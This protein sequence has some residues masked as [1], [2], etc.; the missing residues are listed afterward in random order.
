MTDS[1]TTTT[2]ATTAQ[3]RVEID[4]HAVAWLTLDNPSK[5]NAMSMPM[6]RAL[7]DALE[8]FESDPAVRCVVLTGQGDK[9]FCVGADISQ[10]EQIRSGPESSAEYEALTRSTLK[11][12]QTFPKPTIAMIAGYCLGAGAVLATSCDLRIGAVGSRY[13]IPAARLGIG[14]Q[15]SGVK[16]L[17][18][19]V[20]PGH[21]KRILYSADKYPAEEMLRIGFLEELV[22]ADQLATRV[23]SLARTIA[24]NAPLSIATS[25]HAIDAACSNEA[26]PDIAACT[27]GEY[28]CTASEDH[29]EGRRAFMEKRNPVFHGR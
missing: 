22:P 10:F 14:Y 17:T 18:D 23:Q 29:A 20:G 24:A 5:F 19:L 1:T 4:T 6:W 3:V 26:P 21:A 27:A 8:A 11:R 13:G 9:A 12:L 7:R 25:K 28:A 15:Y 16:R 2:I